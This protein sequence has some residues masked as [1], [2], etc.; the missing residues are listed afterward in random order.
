MGE[1]YRDREFLAGAKFTNQTESEGDGVTDAAARHGNVEDEDIV[2][3][4][5]AS[6]ARKDPPV[7]DEVA[8]RP[9]PPGRFSHAESC[10]D[11]T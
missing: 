10:L 3:R 7:L 8:R 6:P 11:C 5:D 4:L 1:D 9:P 2:V